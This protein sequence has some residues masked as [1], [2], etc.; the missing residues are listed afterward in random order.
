MGCFFPCWVPTDC[1]SKKEA[2][3]LKRFSATAIRPTCWWNACSGADPCPSPP[4]GKS[5]V[6]DCADQLG[7]KTAT[8]PGLM[9]S[10]GC[11]CATVPTPWPGVCHNRFSYCWTQAVLDSDPSQQCRSSWPNHIL[12]GYHQRH[13]ERYIQNSIH[14]KWH[15]CGASAW[16]PPPTS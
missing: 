1:H 7:A 4:P 3:V 11:L 8:K 16:P 2:P 10:A 14:K 15:Q 5:I 6:S 9:Q 13:V 12:Q